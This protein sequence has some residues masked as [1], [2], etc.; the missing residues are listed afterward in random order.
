MTEFEKEL[1]L[2]RKMGLKTNPVR[3]EYEKKVRVL[4][5]LPEKLKAEGFK[6]GQ[7]AR[8]MHDKRRELGRLY[9][10]ASPPLFREYIYAATA[11]AGAN[12]YTVA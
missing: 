12:G 3:L 8:T 1:D 6:E 2:I 5:L 7:I 10:E 11:D 4:R 9:K